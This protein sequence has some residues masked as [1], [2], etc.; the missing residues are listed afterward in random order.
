VLGP[1][2]FEDDL[3]NLPLIG[4]AGG[5]AFGAARAAAMEEHHVGVLGAD[6]VERVPDADVIVAVGAAGEGDAGAGRG[7]HFGVG[8]AAGG[9]KFPA[10]DHRGGQRPVIDH[11][12]GARPPDGAGRDFEELGRMVA[13]ELEGVAAFDQAEAL[14]DEALE[15]D[16]LDLRA[17][18]LGLAA[19]LRLLVEVEL[20]LD[21][22]GLAVEQVDE[23][24]E[25]IGEIV[26]EARAR[27]HGAEGLDHGVELAAYGVGLGQRARIGFVL[28]GAMAV[29]RKLVEQMRGRRGGVRFVLGVGIEKEE[30][31]FAA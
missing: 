23:R 4:P 30:G 26:L 31:A 10:V 27:Q 16:R 18:L 8:A 14:L 29:E 12:S 3:W 20:A 25:E 15:L 17:V 7:E 6:L 2:G 24:P 1:V 28:A 21:A 9:E 22:I 11:G 13:R 19:A 5:D